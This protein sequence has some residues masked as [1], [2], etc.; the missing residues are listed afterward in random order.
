MIA[1]ASREGVKLR[2]LSEYYMA[3]RERCPE[4][5]VVL[6]Y[7][8]LHNEEIPE[9]VRALRRAWNGKYKKLYSQALNE[10]RLFL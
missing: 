4:N 6:G 9:L 8:S 10:R 3:D 1:S 5:T 7:A 2:G